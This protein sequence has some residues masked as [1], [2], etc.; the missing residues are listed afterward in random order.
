[1]DKLPDELLDKICFFMGSS[2]LW[3]MVRVSSS[4]RRLAMLPYLSHFGISKA[5]IESGTISLS[6]SFFLILVV[7][8]IRP[9]QKLICFEDVEQRSQLKYR[10][11]ASI[12]STAAPIPNILIYNRQYMVHQT[13]REALYLL[14][15]IPSVASNALL[16]V[17]PYRWVFSRPR[18]APPIRWK[19][20]PPP[21]GSQNTSAPVKVLIVM[22]GIPLLFAYLVSAV[23]NTFVVL[24]WIYH[25][26]VG[27][28]WSPED[29]I[30]E[31]VGVLVFDKWMCIQNVP[32]K[33]TLV[34]LTDHNNPTCVIKRTPGLDEGLYS[35]ILAA[36][37]LSSHLLTLNVAPD[38]SLV[39]TELMAFIQRHRTLNALFL[40]HN[41]IQP[42]SF[43]PLPVDSSS[44][45]TMLRAPAL[46][47][48]HLLPAAPNI[49][50]IWISHMSASAPARALFSNSF[51]IASYRMALEAIVAL[52]GTHPLMLFL[53]LR[54]AATAL[55]WSRLPDL[56]ARD[57]ALVPETRLSRVQELVLHPDGSGLFRLADIRALVPWLGLF[58]SLQRLT[59][60]YGAIEKML[61]AQ[62]AELE[63]AICSVCSGIPGPQNIA[64]NLRDEGRL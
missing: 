62:R 33:L 40:G 5:N 20:L 9:I 2:E 18:S 6:D 57:A 30:R 19:L 17:S 64:F 36:L 37:D 8:Q 60:N 24:N 11:L 34:T 28:G 10:R 3:A 7:A 63:E 1:M 29:R 45:I 54:P 42:S 32:G 53:V 35:S 13:R 38:V 22:F 59:F 23:V 12:L 43:T 61:A 51:D 25:R 26:L 55:P 56:E 4:M 50:R 21:F 58:P 16:I 49:H 47:I 15:R 31:D 44:R 41:S 39:Y 46:Y 52:P 48:P 27:S 14:S